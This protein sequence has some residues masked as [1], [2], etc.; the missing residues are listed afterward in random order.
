MTRGTA[1]TRRCL[2]EWPLKYDAQGGRGAT[3]AE[4]CD[5]QVAAN[6]AIPVSKKS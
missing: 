2:V 1:K 3:I 5:P 4:R 6:M